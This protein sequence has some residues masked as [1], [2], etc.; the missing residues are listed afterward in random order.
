MKLLNRLLKDSK[1]SW[2]KY[3]NHNFGTKIANNTL[4]IN[5]FNRYIVQDYYYLYIYE[6]SFLALGI[7]SRNHEEMEFSQSSALSIKK[8]LDE[9]RKID[10]NLD[11]NTIIPNKSCTKYKEYLED[12]AKNGD[13]LDILISITPC[14]IGYYELAVKLKKSKTI[15]KEYS[16]WIDKCSSEDYKKSVESITNRINSFSNISEFKYKKLLKIFNDITIIED[17]FFTENL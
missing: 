15:R 1:N 9:L 16:L 14:F 3:T 11:I 2:Y 6:K 8:E 5:K 4:D 13:F 7:S 12:I 10:P 17:Q